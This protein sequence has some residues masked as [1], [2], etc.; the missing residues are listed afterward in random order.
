MS[1]KHVDTVQET[2]FCVVFVQKAQHSYIIAVSYLEKNLALATSANRHADADGELGA[3]EG[4]PLRE[5]Y[6]GWRR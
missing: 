4:R 3:S 1:E 2:Y 6:L 5:G